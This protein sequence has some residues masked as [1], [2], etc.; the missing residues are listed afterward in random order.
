VPLAESARP[1]EP[2]VVPAPRTPL[3]G[4][5]G[6]EREVL[7]ELAK[8]FTNRE[9]GQRL[10]IS[11][12]TVGVHVSRIFHKFGVHSRVQASAVLQRSRP[13]ADP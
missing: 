11:E 3:D 12:K 6:R 5:T 7:E 4:L 9:I 10:Y 1:L 8:G 2:S 13:A